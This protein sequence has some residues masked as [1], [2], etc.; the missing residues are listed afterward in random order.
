[1]LGEIPRLR[2]RSSKRLKPSKTSRRIRIVHHSPTDS[3]PS[4]IG[5]SASAKLV[6]RMAQATG[7]AGGEAAGVPAEDAVADAGASTLVRDAEAGRA[8]LVQAGDLLA[9]SVTSSA[10]R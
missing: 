6:R 2:C 7:T 4:A 9:V 3:R 1:M 10:A 5:H 8:D